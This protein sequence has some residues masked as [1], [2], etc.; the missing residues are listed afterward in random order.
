[1][2]KKT[3]NLQRVLDYYE[4][5][6]DNYNNLKV[7]VDEKKGLVYSQTIFTFGLNE[8]SEQLCAD[9][10]YAPQIVRDLI[11]E[12]KAVIVSSFEI[13]GALKGFTADQTHKLQYGF[14]LRTKEYLDT[15]LF[16]SK[17]VKHQVN[18]DEPQY[19]GETVKVGDFKTFYGDSPIE[20]GLS[21]NG[22]WCASFTI[23]HPPDDYSINKIYFKEKPSLKNIL[24]VETIRDLDFK[25]F[26][27]EIHETFHCW[28]CGCEVH[29]LDT[30]GCTKQKI[31]N[32]KE[33]H[34]GC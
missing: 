31:E 20:V 19:K 11:A 27:K 8:E 3:E 14:G 21:E 5:E 13:I 24:A 17:Y 6:V 26:K 28:E 10:K 25:F 30:K 16:E 2:M 22:L 1:M 7:I 29:W 33:R 9:N 18:W 34:C 12:N 23:P 15:I 4:F 32:M